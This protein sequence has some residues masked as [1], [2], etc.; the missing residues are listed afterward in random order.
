M[1]LCMIK[2]PKSKICS[3]VICRLKY[4]RV[5]RPCRSTI[6]EA[7]AHSERKLSKEASYNKKIFRY[8]ESKCK[9]KEVM[10]PLLS[11]NGETLTEDKEQKG[12]MPILPPF[13]P[14]RRE[15]AQLLIV[16]GR[17]GARAAG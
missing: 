5:A 7:K 16:V 3:S 8:M 10:G 14:P 6:R 1:F 13:L 15:Q 9:I 11:E 12:P 2:K 17:S 4:L